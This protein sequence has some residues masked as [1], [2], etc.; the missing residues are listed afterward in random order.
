MA[1]GE[2]PW[3]ACGPEGWGRKGSCSLGL[4]P[5]GCGSLS[6]A[7]PERLSYVPLFPLLAGTAASLTSAQE[8]L[9]CLVPHP[10]SSGSKYWPQVLSVS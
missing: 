7:R 10:D 4:Q 8:W 2:A 5:K 9:Q 1:G 3:A 6:Q